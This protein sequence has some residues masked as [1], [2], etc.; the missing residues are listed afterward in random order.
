M[1]QKPNETD[2]QLNITPVITPAVGS[3]GDQDDG[4]PNGENI[5]PY[6]TRLF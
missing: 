1:N 2:R 5:W 3:G 4:E 6:E